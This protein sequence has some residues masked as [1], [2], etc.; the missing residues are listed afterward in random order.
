[1]KNS[2][3]KYFLL[4]RYFL[5]LSIIAGGLSSLLGLLMYPPSAVIAMIFSLT[6]SVGIVLCH[7]FFKTEKQLLLG[8]VIF[9]LVVGI[10]VGLIS[11]SIHT[12]YPPP[13]GEMDEL[14]LYHDSLKGISFIYTTLA[15]SICIYLAYYLRLTIKA[16]PTFLTA[17]LIILAGIIGAYTK[18]SLSGATMDLD[19][20]IFASLFYGIPFTL[21]WFIN[22]RV[23]HLEWNLNRGRKFI[24]EVNNADEVLN[25]K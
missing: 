24:N 25:G 5:I 23:Y 2:L 21:F 12:M 15:Y 20:T 3:L 14:G 6:L 7:Y 4:N 13:S 17:I 18:F 9:S 16:K 8:Y 22:A 10:V 11:I 1:M 19:Y